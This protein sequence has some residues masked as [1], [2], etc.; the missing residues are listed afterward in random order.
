MI[1]MLKRFFNLS[2]LGPKIKKT[3][4]DNQFL[5]IFFSIDYLM[6]HVRIIYKK[7]PKKW[8][9]YNQNKSVKVDPF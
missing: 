6:I 3:I 1:L 4:I 7:N 5:L 2:N 8:I 9:F